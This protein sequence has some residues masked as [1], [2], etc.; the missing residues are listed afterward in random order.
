MSNKKIN[1]QIASII[2][3][4]VILIV[5]LALTVFK[6]ADPV[7]KH[8]PIEKRPTIVTLW[9][10]YVANNSLVTK[11]KD[12]VDKALSRALRTVTLTWEPNSEPD[13]SH[14]IVY[15]GTAS[16]NYTSN[17][18]NI[19]LVTEHTQIL[20][21]DDKTYF[22][23]VTAIDTSGLESDFSNERNTDEPTIGNIPDQTVASGNLVTLE[24]SATDPR[25]RVMT[26]KWTQTSGPNITLSSSTIL[27][28]TFT[29]PTTTT[30]NIV[31]K[32]TLRVDNSM[33]YDEEECII[34]VTPANQNSGPP[35]PPTAIYKK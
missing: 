34:T 15:W 26:Y 12:M 25:G 1:K 21:D 6:L 10:E 19:G 28:P 32:F 35:A 23:A 20:P 13:L 30:S 17:S 9:D 29:A 33:G 7:K 27:R 24:G 22:F 11:S 4:S 14:Y 18:G 8:I 2:I 3:C 31:L 5:I 16:G